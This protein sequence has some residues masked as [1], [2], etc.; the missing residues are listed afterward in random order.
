M[1]VTLRNIAR[2]IDGIV[3]QSE[4]NGMSK[5]ETEKAR[6]CASN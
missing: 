5:N 3:T 6:K 2:E 4:A 1:A